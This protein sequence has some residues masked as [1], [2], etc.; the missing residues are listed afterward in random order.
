MNAFD[1]AAR[2]GRAEQLREEL[3]TLFEKENQAAADRTIIPATYLKVTV[4]KA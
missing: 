4:K 2:D 3:T 1:A